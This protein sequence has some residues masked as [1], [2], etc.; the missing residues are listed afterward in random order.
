MNKPSSRSGALPAC[1][2]GLGRKPVSPWGAGG[3]KHPD[4]AKPSPAPAGVSWSRTEGPHETE[5]NRLNIFFSAYKEKAQPQHHSGMGLGKAEDEDPRDAG[6]AWLAGGI[7][8]LPG[9]PP[10]TP[11]PGTCL[12]RK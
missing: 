10:L 1:G 11:H 7:S 6:P 2:A 8:R 4:T 12:F 5:I 9:C 3:I